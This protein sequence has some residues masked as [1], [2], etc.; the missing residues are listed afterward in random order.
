MSGRDSCCRPKYPKYPKKVVGTYRQ[1]NWIN[2][3]LRNAAINSDLDG[4]SLCSAFL[5]CHLGKCYCWV[6][7][8]LTQPWKLDYG[9]TYAE[10][11]K[12]KTDY[13]IRKN[14][15]KCNIK[16]AN[17]C[18]V[19]LENGQPKIE[20][21]SIMRLY[22]YSSWYIGLYECGWSFRASIGIFLGALNFYW[23][24]FVF[25]EG[26]NDVFC[27]ETFCTEKLKLNNDQGL[28]LNRPNI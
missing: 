3:T 26:Q 24:K 14:R 21:R 2:A 17:S 16:I 13:C 27:R 19:K 12:L 6:I 20:R 15:Y 11:I 18:Y 10:N 5:Y 4:D 25:G 22:G 28:Y 8:V 7:W 9:A 23:A 1:W